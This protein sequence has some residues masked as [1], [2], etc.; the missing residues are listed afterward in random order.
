MMI[1][2]EKIL[3]VL[4]YIKSSS[5]NYIYRE[6]IH[7]GSKKAVLGSLIL[8][9]MIFI[10]LSFKLISDKIT[11]IGKLYLYYLLKR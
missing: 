2:N 6:T 8:T 3:P 1:I 9:N 4:K 11:G 10:S 5:L 7:S